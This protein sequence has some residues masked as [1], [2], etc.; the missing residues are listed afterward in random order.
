ML[1]RA[2]YEEKKDDQHARFA[3]KLSKIGEPLGFD[4]GDCPK[5]EKDTLA[6][7]P[8]KCKGIKGLRYYGMYRYKSEINKEDFFGVFGQD[9]TFQVRFKISNK[10]LNY[11]EILHTHYPKLIDAYMPYKAMVYF[12]DYMYE[13]TG[14]YDNTNE[15]YK[16]LEQNPAIRVDWR[17]N[18][19]TLHPAQFWDKELCE[20]ALGYEPEEVIKRL[21]GVVFNGA[22]IPLVM[23]LLDGVYIVLNDDPQLDYETF[24]AMNTFYKDIL[25]LI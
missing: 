7:Y 5:F 6:F 14:G 3:Q 22:P 16:K 9:E 19:Y 8:D 21:T 13:Y 24:V 12:G 20:L 18:I 10:E 15:D 1:Y 17:N 2:K 4:I 11:Q 25:G 23:P